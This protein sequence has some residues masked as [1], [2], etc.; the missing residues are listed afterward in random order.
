MYEAV[1]FDFDGVL[2]DSSVDS[3]QWAN[4]ARREEIERRGWDIELDGFEQGIFE[5]HHAE[6]IAPFL[7]EKSISWHQLR[8][9]EEAVAERKVELVEANE[10]VLFP[11][12]EEVLRSI[13]IPKAVVSNAYDNALDHIIKLLGL[14]ELLDFWT[15]PSL[16]EIESYRD[17]MKPEAHMLEYAMESMGV[18]DAVMVGDQV[19]D[20]LAAEK[21]GIDSVFID[22][23]YYDTVPEP[24]HRIEI[25]EEILEIV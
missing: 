2:L 1:I 15:A 5:P 3:F 22:R 13:D 11:S 20:I 8:L 19:E 7:R 18:A 10:M 25:L 17:R 6:D 23:G 24:D 21:A 12:A 4:Q 9:L 16:S 14:D